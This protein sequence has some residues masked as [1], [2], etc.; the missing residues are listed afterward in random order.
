MYTSDTDNT[1][2][3]IA[4]E[5][6]NPLTMIYSTL[7]LIEAAHPEV[8]FFR[9]W[10]TLHE[11]IL[12]TIRLLEDLSAY[13]NPEE[14]HPESVDSSDFLRR[15]ALSFAASAAD[16]GI[17]FSSQIPELLPPVY[18]DSV[19]LKEALLNLLTNAREACEQTIHETGISTEALTFGH[20]AAQLVPEIRMEASLSD[21]PEDGPSLLCIRI[22]DHGCG[23][24]D[25]RL[26]FIFD[27]FVSFKSGG[28]GLGLPISR[29]II[30]AH[31][32][33]MDVISAPGKGTVFT[34]LLP[35]A[36]ACDRESLPE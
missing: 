25:D 33:T 3:L 9:H 14:L 16:S 23:I 6:R 11:D 30:E 34:I 8:W 17:S 29:R 15:I 27:P 5:I 35:A 28:T 32:G 1:I 10:D 12:Y 7:Q 24:P 13:H 19:K 26:P 31:G 18:G 21:P 22:T 2:R 4:H 20:S 36:S